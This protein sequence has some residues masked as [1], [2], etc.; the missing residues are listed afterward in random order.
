MSTTT[1]PTCRTWSRDGKRVFV[2]TEK[3][4]VNQ[5]TITHERQIISIDIQTGDTIP[6]APIEKED[7]RQYSDIHVKASSQ[8]HFD[9]APEA[10]VLVY[11]DMSGH[12]MY[13]LNV[14]TGG[15]K[16]ILH[17][18]N[19]TIGDPLAITPDGRRVV[20]YVLKPAEK[21]PTLGGIESTIYALDLD[22]EAL[23]TTSEPKAV[24]SYHSHI[25]ECI[26]DRLPDGIVVNHCQVNPIDQDHYCYAHEFQGLRPDG[27]LEMTRLWEN[28]GGIDQ[29]LIRSM[30]GEWQT[31]EV[32]GP[33]GKSI[34]Y[35]EDW[36]VSAIDFAT[37]EKSRIF[38][39]SE[40]R[41]AHLTVS[42]DENWIAADVW[43]GDKPDADGLWPSGILLIETLTGKSR[44]LCR[45]M[46]GAS[47]P[48]HPHPNFSPDGTKI[49]FTAADGP[50]TSQVGIVD[51]S[52]TIK[53]W[54]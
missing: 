42:A 25:V 38:T 53:N 1:Y 26:K 33:L 39:P 30:N 10:D 6:L 31:H 45:F 27:S 43:E 24:T 28:R 22:P 4:R 21:T 18:T 5:P 50:N 49:A 37:R 34:Y 40:H 32:I 2:E 7:T 47:H 16:L 15:L 20:Y 17:E 19:S 44:L 13:L 46:R 29:P 9:Y 51:I 54:G 3:P 11:Y 36:G 48:R 52:D 41:V 35:I 12:R 23:K 8:Y 14:S